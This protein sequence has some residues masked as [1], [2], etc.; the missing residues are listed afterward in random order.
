M[1][2]LVRCATAFFLLA[3]LLSCRTLPN[4]K[5]H[6]HALLPSL[7][8]VRLPLAQA[9]V[10]SERTDEAREILVSVATARHSPEARQAA[11]EMLEELDAG[12]AQPVRR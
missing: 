5:P 8:P 9:Y 12:G 4:Q 10:A 7:L 3:G 11:Q 2:G 6:A 1:A